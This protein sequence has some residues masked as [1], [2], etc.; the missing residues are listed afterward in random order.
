[1]FKPSHGYG[2]ARFC[3]RKC[4]WEARGGKNLNE[5]ISRESAARR[6]DALR[7]SGEGV[8]YRKINGR[9]EHRAVAEAMLGRPLQT[10]EVVHHI[11]GNKLNNSPD[12]LMVMTQ[13]DHMRMHGLGIP[14]MSLP[15]KP[16]EHRK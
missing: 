5:R 12:N 11:D 3:S 9:H 4:I 6:G 14:G 10:N 13:R 7:G 16:W 15:W 8:S 1:M 2:H